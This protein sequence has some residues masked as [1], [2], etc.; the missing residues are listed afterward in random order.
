MKRTIKLIIYFIA[1]QLAFS[2]FPA[3]AYMLRTHS[4]EMPLATDETYIFQTL[5]CSLLASLAVIIHLIAGRY[6]SLNRQN[7]S[8]LS[9][10]LLITCALFVTG[11]GMWSNYLNELL[12]VSMSPQLQQAF[13]MLMQHPLGIISTV[14]MAPVVEELLFRGAI[15]GHLLRIWKKP[16]YAI[17]VSSLLFGLVHGNLVQAPFAFLLGLA[18]GWIYYHTGSLLPSILMHFINNLT[19]TLTYHLSG[20]PDTTLTETFGA[21]G[22]LC[23]ALGGIVLTILCVWIIRSRLITQP[24]AW[25]S[26]TPTSDNTI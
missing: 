15:E 9:V 23:I 22:A 10:S 6:V 7:F 17:I 12:G 14:S 2:S 19:A 21:T 20:D 1:Y 26:T 8:P 11:M 4:F 24:A 5:L 18:L 13:E 3:I 25:V 16:A